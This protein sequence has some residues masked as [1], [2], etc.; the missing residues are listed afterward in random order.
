MTL[1]EDAASQ[2]QKDLTTEYAKDVGGNGHEYY[3][4]H[5]HRCR[6]GSV[7]WRGPRLLL[8]ETTVGVASYIILRK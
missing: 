7:V 2:A 5:H 6:V 8:E 4:A 1:R 3:N